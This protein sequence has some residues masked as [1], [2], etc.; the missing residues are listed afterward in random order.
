[1]NVTHMKQK[2]ELLHCVLSF[3]NNL[4]LFFLNLDATMNSI[5]QGSHMINSHSAAVEGDRE[6]GSKVMG[7]E[8][9]VGGIRAGLCLHPSLLPPPGAFV[10][11]N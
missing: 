7:K 8:V 10:W 11:K 3:V 2:W 1:M 6:G 4:Y 5:I 9:S